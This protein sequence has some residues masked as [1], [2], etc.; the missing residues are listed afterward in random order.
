MEQVA[1]SGLGSDRRLVLGVDNP[2]HRP[3]P[4]VRGEAR[5]IWGEI[6]GLVSGVGREAASGNK[7]STGD[8]HDS[9]REQSALQIRGKTYVQEHTES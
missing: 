2:W 1:G 9:E 8:L 6:I 7:G 3:W 4:H 5:R